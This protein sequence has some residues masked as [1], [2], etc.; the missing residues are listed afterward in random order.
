MS[1]LTSERF[2]EFFQALY[3][4]GP[5]PWQDRLARRAAQA[6]GDDAP[7]PEALALP[8]AAGKTACIDMADLRPG[9]PG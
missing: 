7:W 4:Y 3:G 5:F 1:G 6:Q 9:L 8:T 2:G